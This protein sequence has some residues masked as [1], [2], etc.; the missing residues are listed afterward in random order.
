MSQFIGNFTSPTDLNLIIAKTTRF[1]IYLVTPE[2]LRPVKEVNVYGRITIM[3]L[4]RPKG[5]N[6]DRL[7]ILTFRNQICILE[8]VK[9]GDNFEIITKTHG[10]VA[11]SVNRPSETGSIGIIDPECRIIGLRIYDGLFKII[12]LGKL[13][14]NLKD[15]LLGE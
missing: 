15:F 12:P 8:C 9:D 1:E 10:D 14:F 11:D 3:K 13:H 4:Y 5:E 6:Q 7:F 2:G